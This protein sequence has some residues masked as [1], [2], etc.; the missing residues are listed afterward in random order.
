MIYYVLK[1]IKHI[2]NKSKKYFETKMDIYLKYH[3]HRKINLKNYEVHDFELFRR[4]KFLFDFVKL[5][6]FLLMNC[7][8]VFLN[9]P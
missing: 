9:V 1:S 3:P 8:N 4:P 7:H 2:Q 6:D 5:L